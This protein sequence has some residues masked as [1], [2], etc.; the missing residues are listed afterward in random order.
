MKSLRST[1][2]NEGV[3][4]QIRMFIIQHGLKPGDLIPTEKALGEEL[5]ISR[6]SI[7]EALRSLEAIGSIETRHGVGRFVREFNYDALVS[8]LTH[9]IQVSI[10]NFDD[11]IAVRMALEHTF[12]VRSIPLLT[13]ENITKLRMLLQRMSDIAAGDPE[14]DEL[15]SVHTEFHLALYQPLNNQL[16][17]T[18]IEMFSTLQRSLTQLREYRTSDLGDFIQLHARLVDA[19]EQRD[20]ELAELRL[21]EHFKDVISWST[22]RGRRSTKEEGGDTSGY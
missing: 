9:G 15:I 11:I 20:V 4:D 14:E 8:S 16:L 17:S 7:R 6:T 3:Q 22:Q 12:I 21:Q 10:N 19:L 5:G 2:L 1:R 18:L 13:G